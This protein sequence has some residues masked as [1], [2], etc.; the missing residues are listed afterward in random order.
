MKKL[1]T[2]LLGIS[3]IQVT[4]AQNKMDNKIIITV[5]DTTDLT[6]QVR[7]ASSKLDFSIREDSKKDT[8]ITHQREMQSL[9]GFCRLLAVIVDVKVIVT[10]YYG[11]KK[12]G[13]FSYEKAPNTDKRILYY[14]GSKTWRLIV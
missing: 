7:V 3:L 9:P 13:L 1:L 2:V 10:G 11:L 4:V 8:I 6:T 5:S 12:I 14:S